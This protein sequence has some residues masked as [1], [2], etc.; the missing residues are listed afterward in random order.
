MQEDKVSIELAN[1]KIAKLK[2]K[3][4]GAK[5]TTCRTYSFMLFGAIHGAFLFYATPFIIVYLTNSSM[6]N[7]DPMEI[8]L[9]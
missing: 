3:L 4:G 8:F 6:Y 5:V 1:F 7:R 2:E 9:W